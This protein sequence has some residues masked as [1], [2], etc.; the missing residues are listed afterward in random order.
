[1]RRHAVLPALVPLLGIG[2]L[3]PAAA[4]APVPAAVVP[5]GAVSIQLINAND[6]HGRIGPM[7]VPFAGAVEE[8]RATNP[9]SVFLSAGDNQG[10]SLFTSAIADDEP[11]MDVLKALELKATAAGNHEFD[12]GYDDVVGRIQPYL[13]IP[14]LAANVYTEG[15]TT[16][17]LEEYAVV[18]VG[19]LRV[20]VIGTVAEDLPILV[21]SEGIEGLE[22]GDQVDAVNRVAAGIEQRDEADVIVA[23]IHDG[24]QAG[25]AEGSTW[26]AERAKPGVIRDI[27]TRLTP[28][29]DVVFTAHT[30]RV[31]SWVDTVEATG[32]TRPV[33]QGGEYGK[34]VSVVELTVDPASD[35][36]LAFES[37]VV[38]AST[39][40]VD[41]LRE[42]YPRVAAV[43][44]IVGAAQDA[45]EELGEQPVGRIAADIT[46]PGMAGEDTSFPGESALGNLLADMML[47]QTA[48]LGADIGVGNAGGVRAELLYGDDGVV[49]Y[50]EAQAVMPFTN[51][52]LIAELTG[53]Q[54]RT[55]IEQQFRSG[56]FDALGFSANLAYTYDPAAPEGS[57]VV[58]VFLDGRPIDPAASFGVI[59]YAFLASGNSGFPV[60]HDASSVTDTGQIDL[61]MFVDYL[62]RTLT[63]EPLR[64]DFARRS[65]QVT[66][67]PT[68][69]V[70]VGSPVAVTLGDLDLT[71]AGTPAT[72]S[73]RGRLVAADGAAVD[74]GTFAAAAG[75]ASVSFTVPGVAPGEHLVE[76]TSEQAGTV[77]RIPVTV[78]GVVQPPVVPGQPGT[79]GASGSP[80]T[81][82]VT[83]PATAPVTAPPA[84]T[85][86]SGDAQRPGRVAGGSLA[87]TGADPGRAALAAVALGLAGAG[88]LMVRRR[89]VRTR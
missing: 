17:A 75:G 29:V 65:V 21:S 5:P 66:G 34:N 14:V 51:N 72:T 54:I 60:F 43:D 55:L 6:F 85:G 22:V 27:D 67:A 76:L 26:D 37:G 50:A 31:Y 56:G 87:T 12:Q 32:A 4:A 38:P 49:T 47:T 84:G 89:F 30:H 62:G 53:A 7:T 80:V 20:A 69:P 88:A 41:Q 42:T 77:V 61:A 58:D 28:A 83:A 86:A 36:V 23:E 19:G 15:T 68:E 16:A 25:E 45:A 52:Q 63:G 73:L 11:T 81:P 8:V 13:G 70:A 24:A 71:S 18:E 2:L 1:M 3:A 35:E 33:L 78:V 64:P 82:P 74:L 46:R 79:P 40:P 39:T 57:K 44:A 10:A 48:H 9:N 59:T